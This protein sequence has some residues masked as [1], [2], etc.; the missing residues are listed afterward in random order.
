MIGNPRRKTPGVPAERPPPNRDLPPKP[1]KSVDQSRQA[2]GLAHDSAQPTAVK[3][4]M[5]AYARK[6]R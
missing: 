3:K 5:D 1:A 2:A 6:L 4:L